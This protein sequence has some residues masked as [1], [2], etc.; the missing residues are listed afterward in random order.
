VMDPSGAF[1][2]G[3]NITVRNTATGMVFSA[4]SDEL[5]SYTVTRIPPGEY[6]VSAEL[7]GFKKSLLQGIVL[8]VAQKARVDIALQLGQVTQEVSVQARPSI[9]ETESPMIGSV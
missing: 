7:S 4:V 2:P 3:V 5:G 9:V 8:Q 6:E 1:V